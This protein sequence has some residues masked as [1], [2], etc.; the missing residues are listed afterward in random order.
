MRLVELFPCHLFDMLYLSPGLEGILLGHEICI[1]LFSAQHPQ[2][3]GLTGTTLVSP[4][5][6]PTRILR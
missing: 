3:Q 6:S 5:T 4:S 2:L 1:H